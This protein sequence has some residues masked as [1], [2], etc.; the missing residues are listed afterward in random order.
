MREFR[1]FDIL[2]GLALLFIII[3][4]FIALSPILIVLAVILLIVYA[5]FNL[6]KFVQAK[7]DEKTQPHYDEQGRRIAKTS[8]ID[9]Q[10]VTKKK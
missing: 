6:Y 10:N 2:I 9:I 7:A 3:N 8:I 4:V 1:L 5:G